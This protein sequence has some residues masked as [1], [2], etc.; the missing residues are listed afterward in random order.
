VSFLSAHAQQKIIVDAAGKGNFTSIQLAINSLSDTAAKPRIIFI[1]KGIYK[2]KI[3]IE[4]HN[5]VL[6]GEDKNN[7]VLL[8]S[9][10]RDEFRCNNTDDWGVAT[11]NLKGNDITLK[12][13][14]ITNSYGF[15]N[16]KEVTIACAN[17]TAKHEKKVRKDGHQMALRSFSTT[18]LQ[19]INCILKAY[20]GDTVSPWNVEAGMFYFKDCVME[21][22]VDFYCPRGWAYAE[23]CKFYSHT[24]SAAIWH[25]GSK[26]ES[27]KTVLKNCSFDG[28]E[29]FKLGRWHRDAQFYLIDCK[30]SKAMANEPIYQVKTMN[31]ILWG[32]RQYY[33]NCHR[34]GGDFNWFENNLDK[35][36]GSPNA[37]TINANWTFDGK[38]KFFN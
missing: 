9:I 38:W 16:D 34:E 10:A 24:G 36:N 27:S 31:T 25:D 3:F 1:K 29:G 15:D 32:S 20:G 6:E 7:T 19:V 30:F 5:I 37:S 18:R 8:Q 2:E 28:Y 23:N 21:G 35:A 17:D 22:G 11:I 33:F 4:K 26:Y 12:N 13:L 14:T